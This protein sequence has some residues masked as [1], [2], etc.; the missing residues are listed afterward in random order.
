[1]PELPEVETV[2][3][4]LE[5]QINEQT[6]ENIKVFY[7][8]IL[9]NID[10]ENFS[11]CLFNQSFHQ[12]KRR[13]KYLIFVL[14]DYTLIVHLRMEGKFYI[15]PKDYDLKDK[16]THVIFYLKDKQLHYN[17]VRKFGRM[18]LY[19]NNENLSCLD[20]LGYEPFDINLTGSYLKK[21]NRDN[22]QK[23]KTQLLDQGMIAGI[24]NIYADEICFESKINPLTPAKFISEKKYYDIIEASRKI[25]S[26]AI[27]M[28]GTTIKSYTSSLGVTGLFQQ[29]LMVHSR[30]NST[31][32]LCGS[33]IQRIK[34]NG[35][36]TYFCPKCQEKQPIKLAIT[37]S[38]GSGKSTITSLFAQEGIKTISCDEINRQLLNDE[39]IKADIEKIIDC[40]FDKKLLSDMIFNQTEKGKKTE[41]FL[42]EKIKEEINKWIEENKEE[43][44]LVVEVPLLFESQWNKIFDYNVTVF[45]DEK[46]LYDRLIKNR[47]MSEEQIRE[48]LNKQMPSNN[49]IELADY[50][51]ENNSD[52]ENLKKQFEKLLKKLEVINC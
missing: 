16:H 27:Q 21:Y 35:R 15:Y 42:H 22:N 8:N 44:I 37:G 30:D 13:G 20:K 24:G 3:R 23:I 31:C 33:N 4:T 1:M 26:E 6:I 32:Y 18:Y 7:S 29:K 43:K 40:S 14:D 12:F 11:T 34:V 9:D 17:D 46:N 10:E 50:V 36:S 49:K 25:L 5:K 39:K 2:L 45:S 47:N 19:K 41:Y 28:G 48:R 51:I 38:I 52:E